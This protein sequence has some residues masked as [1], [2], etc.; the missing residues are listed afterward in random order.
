MAYSFYPYVV[1]E[2]MTIYEAASAPESLF[3]ILFGSIFVL[4]VIAGYTVLS[5]TI[6]RGKATELRYD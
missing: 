1:P 6:F 3:I 5:Y 4:P 2:Q